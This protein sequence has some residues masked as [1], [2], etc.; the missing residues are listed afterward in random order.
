MYSD[1]VNDNCKN[2]AGNTEPNT[3]CKKDCIPF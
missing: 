1:R 3:W 2:S